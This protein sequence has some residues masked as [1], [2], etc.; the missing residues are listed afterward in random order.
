ML[1]STRTLL[2]IVI[3]GLFLAAPVSAQ[4]S[5]MPFE[6]EVQPFTDEELIDGFMKTAFGFEHENESSNNGR[7]VRFDAAQGERGQRHDGGIQ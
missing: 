2:A 1:T 5:D 7:L 3:A 6:I 4:Q